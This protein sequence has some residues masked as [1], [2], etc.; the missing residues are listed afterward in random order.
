MSKTIDRIA[1]LL[2]QA[3]GTTNEHEAEAFMAKAQKLASLAA[4]DLEVARQHQRNRDEREQP[5]Q[6]QIT[7]AGYVGGNGY[8]RGSRVQNNAAEMCN[9]F[10]AIGGVN[11]LQFDVSTKSLYV[12]AY[13]MP[14]DIDVTEALYTSL[15]MQ[16]TGAAAAAVKAGVH[17]TEEPER[18]WDER[19]GRIRTL[20]P[21]AR[22][23][24]TAFYR[25]FT[26]R[27]TARLAE[28]KREA[29]VEV[30]QIREAEAASLIA[31]GPTAPTST[32]STET[33]LV[34]RKKE[35]EVKAFRTATTDAKGTWRG[36]ARSSGSSA[37]KRA[38][39]AAGDSARLGAPTSL[40]GARKGLE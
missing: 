21:D 15:L 40:P 3:E 36:G 5:V 34:L 28:A 1:A 10:M 38:G 4:I 27:V 2:A 30:E 8:Y 35:E 16:M 11:D 14:T 20:R 7:I 9:L 25:A 29:V 19:R 6:R 32:E 12:V 13:G 33:A 39:R 23:F 24:K 17:K 18:V 37:G 22:R 26:S 31:A